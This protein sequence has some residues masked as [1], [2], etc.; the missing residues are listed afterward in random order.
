V[1]FVAAPLV[2]RRGLA[3][4]RPAIPLVL[5]A[6]ACEVAGFGLY[7]VAARDQ[8]AVAAV[9]SSQFAAFAALGA[10]LVFGERLT[11]PQRIG[12]GV[13]GLGVATLAALV[14]Q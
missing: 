1:L 13:I 8:I 10:F 6:G 2:A 3:L 5:L 11:T 9:L 12:L 14:E 7:S 4:T